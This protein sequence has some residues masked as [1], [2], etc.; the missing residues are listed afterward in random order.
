L[1]VHG[2][3]NSQAIH[4]AEGLGL[5]LMRL[6]SHAPPYAVYDIEQEIIRACALSE[7]RQQ[8]LGSEGSDTWIERLLAGKV[9]TFIEAQ[10]AAQRD[11]YT[12]GARYAV[13]LV[14]P[15]C[16]RAGEVGEVNGGNEVNESRKVSKQAQ[17]QIEQVALLLAGQSR[18]SEP[19]VIARRFEDGLV[20]LVP[21]GVEDGLGEAVREHDVVCGVGQE[22][23]LL[24]AP[25]SL[26]EAR[27]ALLSSAAQE[28]GRLVRYTDLGAERMVL[29]LYQ[30]SRVELESFVQ[31]TLGPLLEYDS[32]ASTPLL[33]TISLLLQHGWR[34]GDAAACIRLNRNTLLYRVERAAKILGV[35]LKQP[36]SRLAVQ[37]ALWA[38]PLI[39]CNN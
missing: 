24:E 33:P 9:A 1:V 29:L 11:G 35:D 8:M 14:A 18:P 21:P 32:T 7:A 6:P 4:A 25:L 22:R 2:E 19:H 10:V 34:L 16:N 37:M 15:K 39:R 38:L 23:P 28:H 12:L 20:A 17:D 26:Q 5:P 13:A 31:Q 36:E 3:V 30:H 27:L